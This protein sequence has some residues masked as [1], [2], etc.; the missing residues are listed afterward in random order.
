MR[1]SF[2]VAVVAVIIGGASAALYEPP[3]GRVYLSIWHENGNPTT[4]EPHLVRDTPSWTNTRIGRNAA[5]YQFAQFMPV[6]VIPDSGGFLNTGDLTALENTQTD[7]FFYLTVY[8]TDPSSGTGGFDAITDAD[9]AFLAD[10]LYNITAPDRS[11]RRVFLRLFPEMNGNWHRS[12][13][14]RPIAYVTQWRRV[15]DAIVRRGAKDRVAMVWSPNYG[16]SYPFGTPVTAPNGRNP[17]PTEYAALDT[18]GD[19][20][21]DYRDDPFSPWYPGDQYV[22]WQ[23]LSVYAKP[24]ESP[25]ENR[26]TSPSFERYMNLQNQ[27]HPSGNGSTYNGVNFYDVY[28]TAK[29]KPF[30]ISES[31]AAFII[32]QRVPGNSATIARQV[33]CCASR[34]EVFRPFWRE[35]VTNPATLDRYPL[36]KMITLFEHYK[37]DDDQLR[38]FRITANSSMKSEDNIT[39]AFTAD[40]ATVADRYIWANATVRGGSP[41]QSASGAP[42]PTAGSSPPSLNKPRLLPLPSPLQ[43]ENPLLVA[44]SPSALLLSRSS[45]RANFV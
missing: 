31:G 15:H 32:D 5:S 22:D 39:P 36:M 4:A 23:G 28:A 6:D 41:T 45:A 17:D 21:V 16:I 11:N 7:A 29:N 37:I 9:V 13:H 43:R 38:D 10:Q 33:T 30:M 24:F 2:A 8:P 14:G 20:V 26:A 44:S 1:P 27:A 40:L 42:G 12:W 25:Q 19:G 35:Y 3:N 34:L 18:N